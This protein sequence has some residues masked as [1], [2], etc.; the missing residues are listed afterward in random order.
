MVIFRRFTGV[1]TI[2]LTGHIMFQEAGL[3]AVFYFILG[4]SMWETI[5]Y[6][7]ILTAIYFSISSNIIF[8]ATQEITDNAGFSIG[9]QQQFSCWIATKVAPKLGDKSDSVDNLKLPKFLHIFHDSIAST[10]IIMT[11]FFDNSWTIK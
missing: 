11:L 7:S 8:K 1:R 3:I 10:T 4:A 9:H 5:I 6:S 2:M